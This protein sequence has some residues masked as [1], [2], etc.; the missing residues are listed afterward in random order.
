MS[1]RDWTSYGD[2]ARRLC[3]RTLRLVIATNSLKLTAGVGQYI[4]ID[5]PWSSR[6][7]EE[8]LVNGGDAPEPD[9]PDHDE[10]WKAF[11]DR[12]AP[13][14]DVVLREVRYAGADVTEFLFEGGLRLV[15]WRQATAVDDRLGYDDWYA[16]HDEHGGG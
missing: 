12:L 5:P 6:A 2:A 8:E 10:T 11:C 3:G 15:S 14:Q 13:L 16:R 1:E 4:W 9:A 7:S